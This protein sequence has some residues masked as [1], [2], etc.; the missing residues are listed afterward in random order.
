MPVKAAAGGSGV[1]GQSGSMDKTEKLFRKCSGG[2]DQM[3]AVEFSASLQR[4]LG[5]GKYCTI[6]GSYT[7]SI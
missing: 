3:D 7:V 1:V 5:R 2:D 4:I 6:M